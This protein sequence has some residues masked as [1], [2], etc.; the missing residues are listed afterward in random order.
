MVKNMITVRKYVL[1][2]IGLFFVALGVS[3]SVKAGIGVSPISS[4]AYVVSSI[5]PLS[6]GTC[7][8]LWNILLLV[9]QIVI[10]RKRFN[11]IQL[12]QIPLSVVFGFFTDFTKYIVAANVIPD[13]YIMKLIYT[14][15][16][17][18]SIALGIALSLI[19]DVVLNPG[20]GFVKAISDVSGKKF[21]NVKVI[22]DVSFV[23]LAAVISF[24]VLKEFVGI[25]EGTLIAAVFIGLIVK[26][27]MRFI[28]KPV[29]K[30]MKI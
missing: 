26:V 6:L 21:G 28:V 23:A 1:F 22:V 12:M 24:A 30:I 17:S 4:V 14:V 10:L 13:M 18:V 11:I 5:V 3:V 19:A 20:E 2:V 25:R 9:L 8:F 27:F 15:I 29:K 7:L 16:G